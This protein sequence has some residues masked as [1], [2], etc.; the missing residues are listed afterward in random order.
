VVNALGVTS[1]LVRI[2][3]V[4]KV[5]GIE[6]KV[7]NGT[8]SVS[9]DI[10]VQEWE[11]ALEPP[12][13]FPRRRL[14]DFSVESSLDWAKQ[15]LAT[16]VLS[17]IL[18]YRQQCLLLGLVSAHS[19]YQFVTSGAGRQHIPPGPG[20]HPVRIAVRR[21]ELLVGYRSTA[22]V[23]HHGRDAE[24]EPAGHPMGRPAGHLSGYHSRGETA[25]HLV[26]LD[27]QRLHYPGRRG[28]MG[29]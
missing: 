23:R 24:G 14:L 10:F 20:N 3:G 22:R 18:R 6:Y 15:Q 17:P 26:S 21:T 5:P 13:G 7:K 19:A 25:G 29:A 11:P 1:R 28:G 16:C 9:V 4:R 8:A 12:V 27:R 2:W